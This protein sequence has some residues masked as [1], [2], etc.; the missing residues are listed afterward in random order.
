MEQNIAAIFP[1]LH[2]ALDVVGKAGGEAFTFLEIKPEI[3]K[4]G[5][6]PALTEET[7]RELRGKKNGNTYGVHTTYKQQK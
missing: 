2:Q 6:L 7:G 4:D 3:Q 1:V 5:T